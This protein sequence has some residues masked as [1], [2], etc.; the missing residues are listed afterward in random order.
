[1]SE[2][3]MTEEEIKAIAT[4]QHHPGGMALLKWLEINLE[5]Y[6]RSISKV[7]P[8]DGV[9]VAECQVAMKIY[10]GISARIRHKEVGQHEET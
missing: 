4:L 1:M 6:S 7:D 5:H 2:K 8:R 3:E 9:A 10:E